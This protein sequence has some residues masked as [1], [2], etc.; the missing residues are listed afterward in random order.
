VQVGPATATALLAPLNGSIAFM[1]D[2]A[3]EAIP[4]L[5]PKK[6]RV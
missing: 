6:V 2:E 4:A 3:M 1:S 5:G